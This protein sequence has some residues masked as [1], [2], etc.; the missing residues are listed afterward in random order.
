M[1]YTTLVCQNN[2]LYVLIT[3][4]YLL[5]S[6]SPIIMD[7]ELLINAFKTTN[8]RTMKGLRWWSNRGTVQER[9]SS[10]NDSTYF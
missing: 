5:Q 9:E 4:L 1:A 7:T 8:L 2:F 10:V 3:I 6:V